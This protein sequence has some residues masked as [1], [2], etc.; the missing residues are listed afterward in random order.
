MPL[1]NWALFEG[2]CQILLCGFFSPKTRLN[3]AKNSGFGP[4]GRFFGV[5]KGADLVVTLLPPFAEI[6]FA[7]NKVADLGD[8]LP[9]PPFMEKIRKVVIPQAPFSF[10]QKHTSWRADPDSKQHIVLIVHSW[11]S[12]CLRQD[13]AVPAAAGKRW[14]TTCRF[15]KSPVSGKLLP[16]Y[17]TI[18]ILA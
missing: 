5:K 13:D 16:G 8:N 1:Q 14:S 18:T 4:K 2:V 3:R 17:R 6:Y 11:F 7:E 12:F 9:P 15:R 10:H